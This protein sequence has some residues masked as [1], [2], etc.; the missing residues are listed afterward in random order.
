M[1]SFKMKVSGSVQKHFPQC[2][3]PRVLAISSSA[4]HHVGFRVTADVDR[5]EHQW[6]WPVAPRGRHTDATP[7]VRKS[8]IWEVLHSGAAVV[9]VVP[10]VG[11]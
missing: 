8:S 1:S 7:P 5:S 6:S 3:L 9:A 11:I 10:A 4:L 2:A